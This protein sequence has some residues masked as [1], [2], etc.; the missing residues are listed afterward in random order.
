[1]QKLFSNFY[2]EMTLEEIKEFF[3]EYFSAHNME[4]QQIETKTMEEID[5]CFSTNG[6]QQRGSYSK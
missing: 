3:T 4:G 1:M 2:G 6:R 5:Y